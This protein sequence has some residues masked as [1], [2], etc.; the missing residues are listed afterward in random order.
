MKF[1]DF[2][3]W[4]KFY[5]S[6]QLDSWINCQQCIKG[7]ICGPGV[8]TVVST[9]VDVH[10]EFVEVGSKVGDGAVRELVRMQ[11]VAVTELCWCLGHDVLV[12]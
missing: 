2:D 10:I 1:T 7:H 5:R 4:F 8:A 3:I 12:L 9:M 11:E 6:T